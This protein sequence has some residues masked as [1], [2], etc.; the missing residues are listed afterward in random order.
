MKPSL[1]VWS[2]PMGYTACNAHKHM[3]VPHARSPRID[4]V[5][6]S[7][8]AVRCSWPP[9]ESNPTLAVK[10]GTRV[11]VSWLTHTVFREPFL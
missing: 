9:Q 11:F 5:A 8:E 10:P 7:R 3:G 2:S 6:I 4:D 1:H